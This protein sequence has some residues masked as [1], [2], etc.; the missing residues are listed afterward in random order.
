MKKPDFF[1]VLVAMMH[2]PIIGKYKRR[3]NQKKASRL[4][5]F[6]ENFICN[7]GNDIKLINNL[8]MQ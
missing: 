1:P 2:L 7:A 4:Q 8:V 5:S 6:S 3:I